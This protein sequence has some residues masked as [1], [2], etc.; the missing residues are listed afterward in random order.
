MKNNF[1]GFGSWDELEAALR[2][3]SLKGRRRKWWHVQKDSNVKHRMHRERM[4]R[5]AER[6][7]FVKNA[8]EGKPVDN[9]EKIERANEA[10]RTGCAGHW[11]ASL[12][13]MGDDTLWTAEGLRR[14]SGA[15]FER[16]LEIYQVIRFLVRRGWAEKVRWED[17]PRAHGFNGRQRVAWWRVRR[18][19]LGGKVARGEVEWRSPALFKFGVGGRQVENPFGVEGKAPEGWLQ[20]TRRRKLRG[21]KFGD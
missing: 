3:K 20:A 8:I 18:T 11:L 10:A 12:Q 4:T 21:R 17:A 5:A 7:R 15:G 2:P 13:A 14:A 19:E 16:P 6:R 1:D 9:A